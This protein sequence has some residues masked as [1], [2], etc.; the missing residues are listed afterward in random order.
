MYRTKLLSSLLQTAVI[1]AVRKLSK[2]IEIILGK[3]TCK[4]NP[5]APIELFVASA[6]SGPYLKNICKQIENVLD[7]RQSTQRDCRIGCC[8]LGYQLNLGDFPD[9]MLNYY[10]SPINKR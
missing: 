5:A 8:N 3:C 1:S 4:T 7:E 10:L 6:T 9:N 2:F